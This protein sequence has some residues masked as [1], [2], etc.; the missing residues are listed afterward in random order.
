MRNL[1]AVLIAALIAVVAF[2]LYFSRAR[3]AGP[4]FTPVQSI[5]DVGVKN[6]LL[7]IAQAERTYWAEHGS[8]ASL[9]E[10]VSSGAVSAAKRSRENYTY[11]IETGAGGFT[12]LALCQNPTGQPCPGYSVDQTM[13]VHRAP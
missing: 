11:S 4:D 1:I 12:V 3:T 6:D 10:L 13:E 9:D 5:A 2:R 7:Q 8:Y